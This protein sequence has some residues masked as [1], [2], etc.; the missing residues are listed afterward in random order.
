MTKYKIIAVV[1]VLFVCVAAS[2]IPGPVTLSDLPLSRQISVV[3]PFTSTGQVPIS[4]G[5]VGNSGYAHTVDFPTTNFA[6]AITS[7]TVPSS[8]YYLS[9]GST[10]YVSRI[11]VEID[12]RMVRF[13]DG[14]AGEHLATPIVVPPN[15]TVRIASMSG[16]ASFVSLVGYTIYPNEF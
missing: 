14:T 9:S 16:G 8:N 2:V 10:G 13:I 5:A 12:G 1:A 3:I 15:S 7:I 4:G 11:L 6:L